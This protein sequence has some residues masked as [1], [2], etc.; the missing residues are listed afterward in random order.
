MGLAP[1]EALAERLRAAV[2]DQR[3]VFGGAP[4][5]VTISVGVSCIPGLGISTTIDFV[6]RADEALYA[7]KRAG[8][9]RVVVAQAQ[10]APSTAVTKP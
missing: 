5:P 1:A 2:E 8:R 9:N 7:A 4:I 6:A 10:P 3:F